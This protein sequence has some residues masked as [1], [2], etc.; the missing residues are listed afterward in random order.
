MAVESVVGW[1]WNGW[2]NQRGITGRM[3]VKWVVEWAWNTQGSAGWGL[4]NRRAGSAAPD[5]C[6]CEHVDPRTTAIPAL[7]LVMTRSLR[8]V[9]HAKV[10]A[11]DAPTGDEAPVNP[12][13]HHPPSRCRVRGR[14]GDLGADG[15]VA[16]GR[17]GSLDPL[18]SARHCK[19]LTPGGLD[20]RHRCRADGGGKPANSRTAPPPVYA[21]R[22]ASTDASA[23]V[24]SAQR[25]VFESMLPAAR[26]CKPGKQAKSGRLVIG[27]TSTCD[28]E[29]HNARYDEGRRR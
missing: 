25:T 15:G 27:T 5:T 3:T 20:C 1:A 8:G 19:F 29:R 16:A 4:R 26:M 18:L 2:T 10:T 6:V 11:R 23:M 22:V 7:R 28:L 24:D 17:G 12:C 14:A 9:R 13:A 21:Q